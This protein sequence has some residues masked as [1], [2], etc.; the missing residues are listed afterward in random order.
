MCCITVVLVCVLVPTPCC[1]ASLFSVKDKEQKSAGTYFYLD[2]DDEVDDHPLVTKE[3]K[4]KTEKL[5]RRG[6]WSVDREGAG[7]DTD[8][9]DV[10]EHLCHAC[11]CVSCADIS[12]CTC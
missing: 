5:V 1:V 12:F 8:T 9:E 6:T 11:V 7:T 3:Q 2:T 4:T 10:A